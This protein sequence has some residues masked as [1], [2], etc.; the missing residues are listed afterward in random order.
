MD[1][2]IN[3]TIVNKD[4]KVVEDIDFDDYDKLADHMLDLAD[5]WYE[6]VYDPDDSLEISALN[7]S[8]EVIFKDKAT[9]GETQNVETGVPESFNLSGVSDNGTAGKGFGAE[10]GFSVKRSRKKGK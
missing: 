3:Y 5:K 7:E 6:G 4:G 9:F 2:K 10:I 8:G 1:K